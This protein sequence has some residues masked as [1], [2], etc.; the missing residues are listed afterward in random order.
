M[1]SIL[2]WISKFRE[3]VALRAWQYR[4]K[5]LTGSKYWQERARFFGERAV[6]NLSHSKAEMTAVTETQTR[7]I[8]PHIYSY[9]TG[10]E[11]RILDFGCG[12]GR[13]L[14]TL[15]DCGSGIVIAAD[16]VHRLLRKVS[17][18][19]RICPIQIGS[20]GLPLV[21]GSIDLVWVCLVLGGIADTEIQRT[22]EELQRVLRNGGTLV[23]V[24]NTSEKPSPI[25]WQFRQVSD[26]QRLFLPVT[27]TCVHEYFDAAERISLM[28]GRKAAGGV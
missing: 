6:Y 19:D 24:E 9:L 18:G 5:G 4:S 8:F 20:E 14:P 26:Y 25:H 3:R 28:I 15:K 11:N 27:L 13:F 7:E 17:V 2:S 1:R 22:A 10:A 12:P 16:P 23:V 21:S